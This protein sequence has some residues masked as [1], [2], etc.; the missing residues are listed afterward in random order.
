[1][2]A[3]YSSLIGLALPV[4]LAACATGGGPA[5]EEPG[6]Q[7]AVGATTA[8]AAAAEPA[9]AAKPPAAAD[10]AAAAAEPEAA[11]SPVAA[12]LEDPAAITAGRRM[13][14]AVCTGYCHSTTPGVTKDA[15]NLFDCAW[16][17]GDTD[18]DLYRVINQGVPDTEMLPFE[19]KIPEDTIWKVIAYMRSNS[20]DCG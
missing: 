7:A 13:F 16:D 1:M 11:S 15:P 14:R 10:V 17:H 19:G 5:P 4:L 20:V 6:A 8:T 9:A 3:R 12:Y 18:A 2:Q